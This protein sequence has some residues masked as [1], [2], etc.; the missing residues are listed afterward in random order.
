[1]TKEARAQL[2]TAIIAGATDCELTVE[3]AAVFMGIG[4]TTLRELRDI[5][6]ADV[7]GTKYLKSECIKYVKAR[8]SHSILETA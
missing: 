1:M 5:P 7:A 3:E 8:L 6:R 2:R 4:E